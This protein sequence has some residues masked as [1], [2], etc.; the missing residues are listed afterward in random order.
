MFINKANIDELD[1]PPDYQT[2]AD[3]E[4]S[5]AI[6]PNHRQ[7]KAKSQDAPAIQPTDTAW[8]VKAAGISTTTAQTVLKIIRAG[9]PI[10]RVELA[11]RLGVS[12]GSITGIVNPLIDQGVLR[13][14]KPEQSLITR[15]G[16][17][18][19]GLWLRGEGAYV[20]GINI[21]VR[22]TH[23]GAETA[24]GKTLAEER[25]YTPPDPDLALEKAANIVQQIR[26]RIPNR[27]M[28]LIGV[29]MPGPSIRTELICCMHRI[30]DGTMSQLP[31]FC[32]SDLGW[33]TIIK[34]MFLSSS[35][36][37]RLPQPFLKPDKN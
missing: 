12:R 1:F 3:F 11:R 30:L 5:G 14:G 20:V 27:K 4:E 25:F 24:D 22:E 21:G 16:R 19:V 36:T 9:Q 18:P 29:S 10:P 32:E 13:E 37:M 26:D 35:K 31:K 23:L 33:E 8:S 2:N 7:K 28:C 34:I 17:P 15:A 6:K